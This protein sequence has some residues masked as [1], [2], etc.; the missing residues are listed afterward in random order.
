VALLLPWSDAPRGAVQARE[1]D[2]SRPIAMRDAAGGTTGKGPEAVRDSWGASADDAALEDARMDSATWG[3]W[4]TMGEAARA[5]MLRALG[6][7]TSEGDSAEAAAGGG[8]AA[9]ARE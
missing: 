9:Y 8:W 6:N 1:T 3:Q 2:R 7:E 4:D 5:S